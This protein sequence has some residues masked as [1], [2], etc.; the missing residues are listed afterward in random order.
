MNYRVFYVTRWFKE[1][2]FCGG[3]ETLTLAYSYVDFL[4]NKLP[5]GKKITF[6]IET[7][8]EQPKAA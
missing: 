1:I 7:N 3:F 8:Q 4:Q 6:K 2:R 5:N